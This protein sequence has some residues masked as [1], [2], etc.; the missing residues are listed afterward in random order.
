[1]LDLPLGDPSAVRRSAMVNLLGADGFSG[2]A[3]YEGLE[4]VLAVPGA[5]V[6]LYGK[7]MT[8]PFRKMGHVTI[9]DADLES[10]RKKVTFVKNNLR[11]IA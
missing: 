9:V 3:R 11:V 2:V 4:E 5:H 1:V 7:R 8:K 6:H 10:L